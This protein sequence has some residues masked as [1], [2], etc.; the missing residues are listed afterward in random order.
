MSNKRERLAKYNIYSSLLYQIV[1]M[2]SGI[3]LPKL[4]ITNFGSEAYGATTSIVQF[5][6]YI[7]LLEGGIGGVARA[8][9]YKPLADNDLQSI[10]AV[11]EEIKHFFKIVG[12]IFI[13]YVIIL[14]CTFQN[15]SNVEVLNW[16]ATFFLV[17]AISISTFSQYFIGISYAVLLQAAQRTYV[18]RL[19]SIITTILNVVTVIILIKLG[20]NIIIVKFVSGLVFAVGPVMQ[21]IY[22][23]KKI[24]L[25]RT[26]RQKGALENKWTGIGQ[27]IAYFLH[28]HT[29]VVVLTLFADLF[30]VAVYSVYNMVI[31][32]IQSI[33][34]S[35]STG[36]EALFGDMY[37]KK[38]YEPLGA[39]FNE[40]ETLISLMSVT[41]FSATIVLITP[42]V[43]L[44]TANIT[45]AEYIQPVFGIIL[46]IASILYSMRAPYHSLVIAAGH[47]KQTRWAAYGEAIINISIS[48][49][50]VKKFGLIGVAIGT[51]CAVAFRFIFYVFYL[52]KNIINRDVWFWVKRLCVNAAMV[53]II[54]FIGYWVLSKLNMTDY[55]HWAV[56]GIIVTAISAVITLGGNYFFYRKDTKKVL[57]RVINKKH[58]EEAAL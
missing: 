2:I 31:S 11:L 14:A 8:A 53:I 1:M 6:G 56:A 10:S 21:W 55:L 30:L 16:S 20:C 45:D 50:L 57:K 17:I 43:S 26:R 47:F 58:K 9:L 18:T 44:Y 49:L 36:M 25:I 27:H 29:D 7:A 39:T 46:P 24:P 3:I 28:T 40:Y 41:L 51:V 54:V 4:Y 22:V 52:S 42:F 5:L 34:S 12:Y 15:I 33:V 32:A 35:F 13:V 38:E 19:I 48:I 37:A 23:K